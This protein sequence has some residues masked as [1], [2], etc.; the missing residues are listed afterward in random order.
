MKKRVNTA[1][2]MNPS[3]VLFGLRLIKRVLPKVLPV[4]YAKVSL[5]VTESGI[6]N[7][8]N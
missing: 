4:K 5:V 7:A 8:Q 2:P 6:N 1:P 3:T